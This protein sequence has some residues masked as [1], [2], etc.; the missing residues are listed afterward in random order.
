M[1]KETSAELAA[2]EGYLDAEQVLSRDPLDFRDEN[3]DRVDD[4]LGLTPK[5]T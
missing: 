3:K 2:V 5:L 1:E 4:R